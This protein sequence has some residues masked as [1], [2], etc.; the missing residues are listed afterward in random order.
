MTEAL[1]ALE[2]LRKRSETHRWLERLFEKEWLNAIEKALKVLAIIKEKKVNAWML[3]I[4][5]DVGIYN[6][7][8]PNDMVKRLTQ[9][10]FELL[11]EELR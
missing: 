1:E 2:E 4:S 5:N 7:S 10:E 3:A 6:A 11:K 9:E 8:I